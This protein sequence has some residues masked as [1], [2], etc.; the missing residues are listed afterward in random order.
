MDRD[1]STIC[2]HFRSATDDGQ[3]GRPAILTEDM[4]DKLVNTIEQMTKAA[5]SKYQV[6]LNMVMTALKMK[7]CEKTARR[8]LH[9]RGVRFHPMREK[10]VPGLSCQ[11]LQVGYLASSCL[12]GSRFGSDVSAFRCLARSAR[13][14]N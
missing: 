7:C 5:D 14:A 11:G 6:T 3:V 9:A 1:K 8:A 12:W 13:T 2:R 4:V 10:P